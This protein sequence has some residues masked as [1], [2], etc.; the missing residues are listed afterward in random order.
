MA[1]QKIA[2]LCPYFMSVG[3]LHGPDAVLAASD[4]G[5]GLRLR[6]CRFLLRLRIRRR[7]ARVRSLPLRLRFRTSDL[8]L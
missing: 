2:A 3:E 7:M 1:K 5:F 6:T 8:G 4:F